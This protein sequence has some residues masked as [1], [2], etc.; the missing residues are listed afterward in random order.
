MTTANNGWE[1]S[2]EAWIKRIDE[3]EFNRELL[4]DAVMLRLAGDVGGLRIVDASCGEGRFCRMLRER[5]ASVTGI[6]PTSLLIAAAHERDPTG[7]YA[8]AI[9]E[10]LPYA[11]QSFDLVVSYVSLVDTPDY[12]GAIVE[13]AR[14]LRPGGRFLIANLGFVSASPELGW[15]RDEQG[16]RLYQ[17]IDNYAGEHPHL[18]SWAGISIL[19]WHR[20][21][22]Y[23]M[24]A[25]LECGLQLRAFEEPIPLDDSLRSDPQ[26]EDWYR[27]PLFYVMLWRSRIRRSRCGSY[28]C[29]VQSCRVSNG[30]SASTST[31]SG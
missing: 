8:L 16:N 19:N 12:R 23:Y 28:V 25:L 3:G 9:S 10:G 7:D 11:D 2:A 22:S 20:P 4:L 21:L 24:T 30:R 29:D 18:L 27:V 6:D 5:G 13:A 17:R 26:F 15:A 1:Q 31:L 14:V